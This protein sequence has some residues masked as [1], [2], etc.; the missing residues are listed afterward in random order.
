MELIDSDG[1]NDDGDDDVVIDNE[2]GDSSDGAINDSLDDIV[3][4]RA[5]GAQASSERRASGTRAGVGPSAPPRTRSRSGGVQGVAV[6][7]AREVD[8]FASSM[9]AAMAG[10]VHTRH[11]PRSSAGGP[12]PAAMQHPS[13]RHSASYTGGSAGR[14]HVA[15]SDR[16]NEDE[17]ERPLSRR[18]H[19]ARAWARVGGEDAPLADVRSQLACAHVHARG[20]GGSGS[21]S[22]GAMRARDSPLPPSSHP[23][24]LDGAWADAVAARAALQAGA[25]S[26]GASQ[27]RRTGRGRTL[28]QLRAQ[29]AAQRRQVSGHTCARG[30]I[31]RVIVYLCRQH[32]C[33]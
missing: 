14:G 25:S 22:G 8:T 5:G 28:N 30:H 29:A 13:R 18:L 17:D 9:A 20:A 23:R 10:I 19:A 6:A 16:S 21:C 1:D 27:R 2:P 7:R 24:A 3:P 11:T 26:S 32:A 4:D 15:L 31:N 33:F 12:C